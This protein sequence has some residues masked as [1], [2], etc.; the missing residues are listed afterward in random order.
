MITAFSILKKGGHGGRDTVSIA[1][2]VHLGNIGLLMQQSRD[3]VLQRYEH[4]GK[5]WGLV[6]EEQFP[7][8]A[9]KS[10]KEERNDHYYGLYQIC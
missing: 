2:C 9:E 8:L 7:P 3:K 1:Q 5:A 4:F 6:G 10:H